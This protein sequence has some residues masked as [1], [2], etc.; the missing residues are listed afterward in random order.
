MPSLVGSEMCIRDSLKYS[1][2]IHL[3][4]VALGITSYT[5]GT[6]WFVRLALRYFTTNIR[7]QPHSEHNASR[8]WDRRWCLNIDPVATALQSFISCHVTI[9]GEVQIFLSEEPQNRSVHSYRSIRQLI[10][11]MRYDVTV[12]TSLPWASSSRRH[13]HGGRAT[14]TKRR[15]RE[16]SPRPD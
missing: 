2:S 3:L 12:G 13:P 8:A 15:R 14:H 16:A 1:A 11:R 6:L 5:V 4:S 10:N 9:L 7:R